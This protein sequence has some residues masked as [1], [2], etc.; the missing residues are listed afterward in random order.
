MK[1]LSKM[2]LIQFSFWDYDTFNFR[3]HGT[4]FIGPNGAG[5]TS[6]IDAVQIALIGAHGNFLQFNTQSVQKDFRTIR[7][8][9]LGTMRSGEG[10]SG[11][12]TRKRDEALS[13]ITLVF[14]GE[15]SQDVVSAGVCIH[16]K[17]SERGHRILGMY[18]LPGVRLEQGHH[19][20]ALQE[21]YFSPLDWSVFE[22]SAR[23]IARK[24]GREPTIT[25][26]PEAYIKELL[27]AI[28][29][30]GPGINHEIFLRALAQ[31][32][33]LK[34][35]HSINDFIRENLVDAKPIDRQGTLRHIKTLQ[36]L[37][38]RI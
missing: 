17:A 14:E 36:E 33:R 23:E 19:L 18:V 37:S 31:S 35:V 30:K 5:K 20:E 26:H 32:L 22:A 9:A 21:G 11:T 24:A 7:D 27:H 38:S 25:V 28:Q 10:E 12:M 4:A 15:R 2:H 8:Y 13:Y 16:S 3:R 1:Q 29:G 34:G 6:L